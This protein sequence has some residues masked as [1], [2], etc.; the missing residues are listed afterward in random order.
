[1]SATD[2]G[3]RPPRLTRVYIDWPAGD[4]L[5][6]GGVLAIIS[7]LSSPEPMLLS[8]VVDWHIGWFRDLDVAT[9]RAV[10]Q[11]MTTLSGTLLGLTLTSVSILAGLMKQD[12]K[13]A[14][15]GLLTPKRQRR[16]S[17]LFFAAL[18]GLA[19]ALVLSFGLLI[20]DGSQSP[21]GGIAQAVAMAVVALVALRLGRVIWVLSLVLSASIAA[22]APESPY[23]LI[24]DDEY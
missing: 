12:L 1:M 13:A 21:G 24:T 9:R 22:P 3:R 15:G 10:Y 2:V 5:V 8:R 23:P 11:T 19:S 17:G 6:V 16:V 7:W 20:A 4:W 18:R 14:T